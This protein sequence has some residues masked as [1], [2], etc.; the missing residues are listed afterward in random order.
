MVEGHVIGDVGH[1]EE[2]DIKV[3]DDDGREEG[4]VGRDD[5]EEE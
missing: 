4:V 2:E 5:V 1:G 3:V